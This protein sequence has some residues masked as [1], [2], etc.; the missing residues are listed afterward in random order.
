[1]D[2]RIATVA[3]ITAICYLVGLIVKATPYNNDK[4][5]P[6]ACGICGGL[7]GV[8]ALYTG[9]A[10]FPANDP[11]TAVAVGIVSGLAATGINQVAKQLNKGE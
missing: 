5:I 7:L 9:L 6:I 8:L 1:M 2:F 10:D 3:A 11:I 4:Y